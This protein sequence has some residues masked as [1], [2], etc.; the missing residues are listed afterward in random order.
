MDEHICNCQ[1]LHKLKTL[2]PA[3]FQ[4]LQDIAEL[5]VTKSQD[6][7]PGEPFEA[8][9]RTSKSTGEDVDTVFRIMIGLKGSRE[10]AL[11]D[12]HAPNYESLQDTRLDRAA[13]CILQCSYHLASSG[14]MDP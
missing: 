11:L 14:L 8:F 2:N 6:Y 5:L 12:G 9:K 7:S 3:A 13:Y 10:V 1:K 4:I